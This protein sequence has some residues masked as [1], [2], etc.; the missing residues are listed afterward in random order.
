MAKGAFRG[1]SYGGGGGFS[2]AYIQFFGLTR[3]AVVI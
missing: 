1:G 3:F 2:G